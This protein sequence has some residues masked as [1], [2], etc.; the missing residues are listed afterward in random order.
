MWSSKRDRKRR[1]NPP[2]RYANQPNFPYAP[3]TVLYY[4]R[5]A[6]YAPS[7]YDDDTSVSLGA[8]VAKVTYVRCEWFD[9]T[10]TGQTEYAM[11]FLDEDNDE[12]ILHADWVYKT[13]HNA[14]LAM[15]EAARSAKESV[16]SNIQSL[17]RQIEEYR[18]E[19]LPALT[20]IEAEYAAK[21][22]ATANP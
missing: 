9:N 18:N 15:A 14:N 4:L 19:A 5:S 8:E 10:R 13:E 11:H 3:G 6:P 21:A 12:R 22:E 1:E 2:K 17:L 16:E 7:Y 20:K